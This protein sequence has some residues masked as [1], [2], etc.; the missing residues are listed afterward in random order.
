M[1][2]GIYN[3]IIDAL[4]YDKCHRFSDKHEIDIERSMFLRDKD[5]PSVM[6]ASRA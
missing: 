3:G 2:S 6:G 5:R 1:T 4:G